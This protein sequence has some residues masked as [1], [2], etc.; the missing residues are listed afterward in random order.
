MID[1]ELDV[2]GAKFDV[3]ISTFLQPITTFAQAMILSLMGTN[4]DLDVLVERFYQLD[5][6]FAC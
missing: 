3:L 1:S 4:F 6:R 2:K 5:L